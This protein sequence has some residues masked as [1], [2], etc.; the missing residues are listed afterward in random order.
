MALCECGGRVFSRLL[1]SSLVEWDVSSLEEQQQLRCEGEDGR[2]HCM[3]V[4]GDLV[5]TW[6][7]DNC[8]LVWNTATGGCDHVLRGHT[9]AVLCVASWGQNLVSGSIDQTVRIWS[10]EGALPAWAP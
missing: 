5:I 4:C 7:D 10:M 8:L 2:V 9:Y 3:T 1:D 6:H